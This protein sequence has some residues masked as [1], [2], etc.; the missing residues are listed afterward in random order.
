MALL[1]ALL[2]GGGDQPQWGKGFSRNMVSDEKGLTATGKEIKWSVPLGS[3]TY[4]TPVVA[5]GRVI[6]GT[7]N[8]KPRDPRFT[9]D[10]GVI[11]CL[12]EK[13]GRLLWQLTTPKRGPTQYHDWPKCGACSPATVEGDR[14]Y[15][16][17]N[18]GE[19]VCLDLKGKPGTT[20]AEVIWTW[21]PVREAGVRQHDAAHSSVLIDGPFLYANTS[22]GLNDEHSAVQNPEAPSLVVLEK[23]TGR[24]VARERAEIGKRTFHCT[25]SSPAIGDVGGRALLVF[26]GGDGVCYAF[27]PLRE[28]PAGDLPAALKLAWKV[29]CDPEAPREDIHRFIRNRREGPSN[30]YGMP[31]I[32]GGRV[33]VA[34]GGDIFWGKRQ[35]WLKCID[36]GVPAWTYPLR[37][38]CIS[39]P[40]VHEGLVYIA[41]V[42]KTVHCVE[43]ATGKS[44]WTH[45][46]EGEMW[47]STM[48][49]DG[50]VYVGTRKGLFWILAA[51]REPKVLAR[52]KLDSPIAATATPANRVLYVA[53][54]QTL[55]AINPGE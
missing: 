20:D 28:A 15:T 36:G 34:Y 31:V 50:R 29:D 51:G 49:A 23:A 22:N 25:W 55:Y 24:F 8:A 46:A 38:N 35:A 21:D 53:T 9:E 19:I 16:V 44:V 14:V 45:D 1:M 17:T 42:G 3:E 6:I 54:H 5:S 18:R 7:N 43:A 52:V 13:D 12:D 26:G 4:S 33:Y 39:T 11:L 2:L 10:R 37:Q 32:E 27:E 41:D 47:A 30:I 40:S 48:V